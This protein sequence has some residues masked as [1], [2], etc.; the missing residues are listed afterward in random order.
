MIDTFIFQPLR[1]RHT[2]YD[3]QGPIAGAHTDG[4]ALAAN[5]T[6]TDTTARHPGK[7]ADGAIVTDAKDEAR[8]LTAYTNGTL[9]D[10]Q[11]LHELGWVGNPSGCGAP[12]STSAA[13]PATASSQTSSTPSTAAASPCSSSTA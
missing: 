9:F 7:G 10:P 3:P 6:I 8:F 1:R 11:F 4:Y 5:G 12:L 13:A 2:A